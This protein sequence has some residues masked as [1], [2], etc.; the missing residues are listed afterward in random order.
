M[1][2][3]LLA[4]A[5]TIGLAGCTTSPATPTTPEPTSTTAAP[6]DQCPAYG[7]GKECANISDFEQWFKVGWVD[8]DGLVPF[9]PTPDR[10]GCVPPLFSGAI[11]QGPQPDLTRV[12]ASVF[13]VTPVYERYRWGEH[14]EHEDTRLAGIAFTRGDHIRYIAHVDYDGTLWR[15]ARGYALVFRPCPNWAQG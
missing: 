1:K 12:I 9:E 2:R 7:Y 3:V 8:T 5:A 10:Q 4:I 14:H 15:L 13:T 6:T 11:N